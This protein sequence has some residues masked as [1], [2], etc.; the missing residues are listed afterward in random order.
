MQVPVR[1]RSTPAACRR[2]GVEIVALVGITIGQ[3]MNDS[4]A[5][6]EPLASHERAHTEAL[7]ASTVAAPLPT[8]RDQQAAEPGPPTEQPPAGRVRSDSRLRVFLFRACYAGVWCV[9]LVL[10]VCV[11]L[12][13][14][15]HDATLVL[16][17]VNAFT[18]YVYL[19][20]YACLAW[21]V[22]QRRWLLAGCNLLFVVCHLSW[23]G[24]DYMPARSYQP[25]STASANAAPRL[26]IF[27]ANLLSHNKEF[28]PMLEEIAAADP[29]II[30]LNEFTWTWSRELASSD[31]MQPYV[32][33][34]NLPGIGTGN[35]GIYSRL[36]VS[37][38]KTIV[39]AN[40]RSC[41]LDV[42]FGKNKLRLFFVHAPRPLKYRTFDYFGFWSLMPSLLAS[43]PEPLIVIGDFNATQYSRAYQ[44]ITADRL[45]SA[46][47]DVGRGYATTWPNGRYWLPP[48]RIDHALLSPEV[49]C[50][51]ITEGRGL[52]SD[53]RPLILDVRVHF[54]E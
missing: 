52:G 50:L 45:R 42:L 20:A 21:A 49:E 34:E 35:M 18:L 14:F 12:R 27:Y 2:I 33:Q 46:H 23:V 16:A 51:D 47:A 44:Q 22:W 54:A 15:F 13:I 8:R 32:H 48:I 24:P 1:R 5:P 43:Q 29:D 28:G 53:H 25:P 3:G 26:R 17:W 9:T 11:L 10:A 39:T 41:I 30:L 40:R 36:P 31:V 19:P 38:T 6:N 7:D 4:T 37:D